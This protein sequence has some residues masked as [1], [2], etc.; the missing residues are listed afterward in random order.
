[1]IDINDSIPNLYLYDHMVMHMEI[2]LYLELPTRVFCEFLSALCEAFATHGILCLFFG[3]MMYDLVNS[4]AV[5]DVCSVFGL[6][7]LV[8]QLMCFKA[9]ISTPAD[10]NNFSGVVNIDLK[11]AISII[12]L[13]SL[14]QLFARYV[15]K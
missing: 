4:N 11:P 14:P 12:L 13:V 8:K 1:M 3:D 6:T 9:D 7:H 10:V 15:D 2:V 5:S